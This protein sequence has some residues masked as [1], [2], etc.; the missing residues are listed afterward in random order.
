[1]SSVC[2]IC[3]TKSV[4]SVHAHAR[5]HA[6]QPEKKWHKWHT[7]DFGG[8]FPRYDKEK[9]CAISDFRN[10]TGFCGRGVRRGVLPRH[11]GDFARCAMFCE[12]WHTCPVGRVPRPWA[13]GSWPRCRFSGL[14]RSCPP[15]RTARS[16]SEPSAL[17]DTPQQRCRSGPSGDQRPSEPCAGDDAGRGVP[18]L[19]GAVAQGWS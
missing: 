6:H 9:A 11:R 10:G 16:V 3:A 4:L 5:P 8:R 14:R 7:P 18:A 2:T 19:V 13:L 1:M 17:R 15:T 12:K